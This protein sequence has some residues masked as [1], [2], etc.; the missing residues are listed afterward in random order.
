MGGWRREGKMDREHYDRLL[1]LAETGDLTDDERRAF[2][3]QAEMLSDAPAGVHAAMPKL[4][5]AA[6]L[7]GRKD[8]EAA[9]SVRE[10]IRLLKQLE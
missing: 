9:K 4:T 1:N 7:M 3:V 2:I 5:H 6:A 10:A 8:A